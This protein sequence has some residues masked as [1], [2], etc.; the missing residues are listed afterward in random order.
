MVPP[1]KLY[2]FT[3]PLWSAPYFTETTTIAAPILP[4]P[5]TELIIL[6]IPTEFR[7]MFKI[8]TYSAGNICSFCYEIPYAKVFR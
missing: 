7:L 8:T 3:Q 5:K 6:D 1:L 4:I 2:Y